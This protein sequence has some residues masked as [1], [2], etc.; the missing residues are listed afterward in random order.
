MLRTSLNV[1]GYSLDVI[2]SSLLFVPLQRTGSWSTSVWPYWWSR[3]PRSS[4]ASVTCGR[5][6][7]TASSPRPLWSWLRSWRSSPASSSSCSRREVCPRSGSWDD[8]RS[9]EIFQKC[10]GGKTRD[11]F[12]LYIFF[13]AVFSRKCTSVSCSCTFSSHTLCS[14]DRLQLHRN[15]DIRDKTRTENECEKG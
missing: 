4:S 15:P 1:I 11:I 7:E 12:Y 14:W 2:L 5:C 10:F 8:W 13:K 6:R 9:L 3:M